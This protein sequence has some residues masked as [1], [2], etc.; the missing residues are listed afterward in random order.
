MQKPKQNKKKNI[1]AIQIRAKFV[2]TLCSV[3]DSDW[4]LF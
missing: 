1:L 3:V 4:G 2:D